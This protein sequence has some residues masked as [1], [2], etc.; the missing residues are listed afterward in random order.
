[1][2]TKSVGLQILWWSEVIISIRVLLFTLPVAI[3]KWLAKSFLM[4][5]FDDRFMIVITATA[6]V[7]CIAGIASIAGYRYWKSVHYLAAI[8]TAVLTLGLLNLAG[9]TPQA[10]GLPYFTP[11]LF[12]IAVIVFVGVLGAKQKAA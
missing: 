10:M 5:N 11:V 7:Y 4:S 9:D 6:L 3:N 8:F 1:M 12:A 2:N